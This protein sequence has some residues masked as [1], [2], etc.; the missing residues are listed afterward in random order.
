MALVSACR[1]RDGIRHL[2]QGERVMRDECWGKTWEIVTSQLWVIRGSYYLG[3][4]EQLVRHQARALQEASDRRD[5][6]GTIHLRIGFCNFAWLVRDDADGATDA[7]AHAL[8]AGG[9]QRATLERHYGLL[10]RTNIA[11]YRN[12]LD[13]AWDAIEEDWSHVRSSPPLKYIATV[14][15]QCNEYRARAHLARALGRPAERAALL[16][17]ARRYTREVDRAQV[18]YAVPTAELLR[19]QMAAIEGNH[20]AALAALQRALAGLEAADLGIHAAVARRAL[21]KLLRG[22]QGAALVADAEAFFRAQSARDIPALCRS[23]APG[24]AQLE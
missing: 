6:Y 5:L 2:E 21:G 8:S 15:F 22:D 16:D 3:E 12:A 4:L 1:P 9:A 13:A 7:L 10:A 19:A 24:L 14:R 18:A 20:T 23:L 11:L 17:Q